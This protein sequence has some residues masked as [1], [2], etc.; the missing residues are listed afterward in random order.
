MRH[1]VF[2][3]WF[4]ILCL[5]GFTQEIKSQVELCQNGIFSRKNNFKKL[6]VVLNGDTIEFT[7]TKGNVFTF[8]TIPVDTTFI[9]NSLNKKNQRNFSDYIDTNFIAKNRDQVNLIY[10]TNKYVYAIPVE[11]WEILCGL[12]V[13]IDDVNKKKGLFTYTKGNC[14]SI[15]N[16]GVLKRIKKS[17]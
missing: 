15:S 6:S 13:C 17:R 2:T 3:L 14:G 5:L 1:I 11:K 16:T 8:S 4:S 10:E 12:Y 9:F 7:H